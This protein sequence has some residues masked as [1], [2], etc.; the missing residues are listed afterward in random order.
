MEGDEWVVH[1]F[2]LKATQIVIE[3]DDV[4]FKGDATSQGD[5]ALAA[6]NAGAGDGEPFVQFFRL[7]NEG[8]HFVG[9]AVNEVTAADR[10]H[11]SKLTVSLDENGTQAIAQLISG[12]W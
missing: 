6:L 12:W 11:G 1:N 7:S 8:P 10:T 9:A 5:P 3:G 2:V 4:F